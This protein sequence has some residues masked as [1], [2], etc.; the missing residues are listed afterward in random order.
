[1]KKDEKEHVVESIIE[2]V[3]GLIRDHGQ[4]IMSAFEK[5]ENTFV[6]PLRI[7][8]KGDDV[9]IS[10]KVTVH[11]HGEKISDWSE[12]KINPNQ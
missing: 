10:S 12:D 6:V 5:T 8:L 11:Y 2:Q 3:S 9:E 7:S 1:M 4:R